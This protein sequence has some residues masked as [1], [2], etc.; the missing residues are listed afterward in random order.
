GVAAWTSPGAAQSISYS[1][2]DRATVRVFAV[3]G[4]EAVAIRNPRGTERVVAIPNTGHGTGVAISADGL[5]LT[6]DHVISDAPLLAVR[7]PGDEAVYPA[8]VVF[9]DP[10][11]DFALLVVPA[12]FEDFLP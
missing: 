1:A 11:R 3:K 5:I 4:V 2:V 6:A 9:R 8:E 10:A 12:H 7:A